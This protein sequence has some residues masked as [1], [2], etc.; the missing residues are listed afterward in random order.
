MYLQE[1]RH[2]HDPLR[3]VQGIREVVVELRVEAKYLELRGTKG[4]EHMFKA[5]EDKHSFLD[6]I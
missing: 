1:K 2:R 6:Q 5:F 3:S 4:F